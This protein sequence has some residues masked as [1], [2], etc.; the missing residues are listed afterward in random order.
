MRPTSDILRD[1][2]AAKAS[3]NIDRLR[4]VDREARV[5]FEAKS[6]VNGELIAA[7]DLKASEQRTFDA[8]LEEM[9]ALKAIIAW[10]EMPVRTAAFSPEASERPDQRRGGS[11]IDG[12]RAGASKGI[13]FRNDDLR[14]VF[15]AARRR[16][17]MNIISSTSAPQGAEVDP[18]RWSYDL[19]RDRMRL[20]DHIPSSPTA[21]P[22]TSY[23]KITTGATAA[24]AVAA[25]G[26]KPTSDPVWTYVLSPIVKVAHVGS[27]HDEIV[28]DYGAFAQTVGDEFISGLIAAET[29]QLLTGSG[30]A[31]N[32]RGLLNTVGIQTQAFST[33]A[34]VSLA[35]GVS[36]LRTNAFVEPDVVVV[37]P[38]DWL[39]ISTFRT[40]GFAATDGPFIVDPFSAEP[41]SL[42][43]TPVIVTTRI[44]AGTAMVANLGEAAR[45]RVR[46]QPTFEI[47]P[48]TSAAGWASNL[49]LLRAEERIGLEV[50]RPA[51]IVSVAVA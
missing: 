34:I 31:P 18:V 5:R 16:Q 23:Y 11:T 1:H 51:A 20:L 47:A 10:G 50:P 44:A 42:W 7:G 3:D 24:T 13:H 28:A 14:D 21:F 36:K 17:P 45:V 9:S 38:A 15:E 43:A 12:A 22:Q 4:A 46:Q 6:E 33:N 48:D 35:N 41:T 26:T 27:V 8:N 2:E 39:G 29:S 32:M 40:G 49:T 25:G 19:A 30:V 37:N